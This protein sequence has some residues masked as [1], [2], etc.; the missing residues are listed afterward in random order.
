MANRW[1]PKMIRRKVLI[2]Q[3]TEDAIIATAARDGLAP[4]EVARV[5][6][7][8]GAAAE[9]HVGSLVA[10]LRQLLATYSTTPAAANPPDS[11]HS[12]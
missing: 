1:V 6:L 10:D 12:P 9:G 3:A 5:W 2:A 4:A 7:E 11:K 8:A